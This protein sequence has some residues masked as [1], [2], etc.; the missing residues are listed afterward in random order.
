M[1]RAPAAGG[2]SSGSPGNAGRGRGGPAGP[3]PRG[4]ATQVMYT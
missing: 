1:G 4:R 3:A 2:Y